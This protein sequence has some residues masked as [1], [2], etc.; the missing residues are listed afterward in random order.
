[1]SRAF[2]ALNLL[3]SITMIASVNKRK[4]RQSVTNCRQ[5]ER[6]PGPLSFR[7]SAIVLKSGVRRPVSHIISTLRAVSHSSRRLDWIWLTPGQLV[8]LLEGLD[9]ARVRG[10]RIPTPTAVS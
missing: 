7:K 2:T 10:V 3:P 9:W 5:A 6:T 1:M 8:A 4:L